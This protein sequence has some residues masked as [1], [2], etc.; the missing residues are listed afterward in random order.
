MGLGYMWSSKHVGEQRFGRPAA[1]VRPEQPTSPLFT[2]AALL[3]FSSSVNTGWACIAAANSSG[4]SSSQ[5]RAGRVIREFPTLANRPCASH[6]PSLTRKTRA[7][8]QRPS[9]GCQE[10]RLTRCTGM[11][12]NFLSMIYVSM[13]TP[14]AG[15]PTTRRLSNV[16]LDM[17][18]E[19]NVKSIAMD[20][21]AFETLLTA[22]LDWDALCARSPH[23]HSRRVNKPLAPDA[24]SFLPRDLEGSHAKPASR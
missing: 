7:T 8:A 17:Q 19:H 21:F 5:A 18:R 22:L 4:A 6:N 2:C 3:F 14:A 15:S 12:F 24:G 23:T 13:R 20:L 11:F 9:S 1:S 10:Q 16:L